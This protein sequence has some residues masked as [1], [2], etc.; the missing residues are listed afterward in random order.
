[1]VDFIIKWFKDLLGFF[2]L[3]KKDAKIVFL[4]LDNAGK[5]TLL[6][7]LKDDRIIQHDPTTMAHAEEYTYGSIKFKAFDLGG[8]PAARKAW[9]NYFPTV[10]AILYM[11]DAADKERFEESKTELN[12][13]LTAPELAKIPIV[14]LGNKIDKKE[15]VSDEDLRLALGLS[16]KTQYGIQKAPEVE[17]RTIELFMCSV[18][19]KTGYADAFEWLTKYLK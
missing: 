6:R 12:D 4:G 11:I 13:I 3:W 2:G 8:H 15:A 9:R 7:R 14:L 10:D 17:G 18:V 19:K 5:T 1:M 16:T